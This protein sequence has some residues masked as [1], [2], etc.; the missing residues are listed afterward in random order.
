V[1]QASGRP[2]FVE[3]A[4][5]EPLGSQAEELAVEHQ[6]TTGWWFRFGTFG[7]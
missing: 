5:P 6:Q 7:L 2:S 4:G 3:T 1:Q